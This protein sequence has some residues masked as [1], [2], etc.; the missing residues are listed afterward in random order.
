[1]IKMLKKIWFVLIIV[2]FTVIY[3]TSAQ[4][5]NETKRSHRKAFS[6]LQASAEA[7]GGRAALTKIE[8]VSFTFAGTIYARNQSYLPNTPL[9]KFPV[10]TK[11]VMDLKNDRISWEQKNT[12]PG[13]LF[14]ENRI[15][16]NLDGATNLDLRQKNH[17]KL[18]AN[19]A[20]LLLVYRLFPLLFLQKLYE[21]NSNLRWLGETTLNGKKHD[22]ITAYWRTLQYT[23]Y[24]DSTTKLLT[25]HEFI[26]PGAFS[27]DDL[28]EFYTSDYQSVNG[29]LMPTKYT[30]IRSGDKIRESTY[31]DFKFNQK[32]EESF[33][34]VSA[35]FPLFQQPAFAIKPL[36][37]DVYLAEGVAGGGYRC[38]IVN[39]NDGILVVDAP[40]TSGATAGMINTIKRTIPGKPINYLVATHYHDD[41]TGGIR[42]F[43]AEGA[44]IITTAA[45]KNFF[46]KF[47]KAEYLIGPDQFSRQPKTPDFM[48]VEKNQKFEYAD[49]TVEIYKL[50]KNSHAKDLYIVYL[51]KEKLLF[52]S[53][54][55]NWQKN[56]VTTATVEFVEEVEKLGLNVETMISSHGGIV[57]YKQVLDEVKEFKAKK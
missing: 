3:T 27:G 35:D 43:F 14:F 16:G 36:A 26:A 10:E 46:E 37:K 48:F 22:V 51:P 40:G 55:Y 53:D 41:H 4:N 13:G 2:F 19:P 21:Q 34:A 30:Q 31:S 15:L 8:D 49:G 42:S 50:E 20:A 32:P 23:L 7:M 57:P 28:W 52:Q 6:V 5:D 39:L 33:F 1:M 24:F 47:A 17:T 12:L 9:D 54:L 29:I 25:K 56:A 45:N 38:L 18:P 44:K 11:V